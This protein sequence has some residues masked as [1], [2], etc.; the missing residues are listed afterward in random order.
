MKL[1]IITI[2]YNNCEGLKKTIDS[3][4]AQTWRDFEWIIIDGGSTDGSK[5]AIEKVATNPIANISFWCSEPDKGIYNAMN[6]G[7][8]KANGEYCFFLNSGDYLINNNSLKKAFAFNFTEDVVWGYLKMDYGD[9]F[10]FA[11]RREEITLQT[12]IEDTVNH[13]GNV[14]IKRHLFNENSYGLYDE[15]LRIV[16][17]WKW[18]LQVL[19]LGTATG[20]FIDI[21][22]SVVDGA[23]ISCTQ[24]SLLKQE[25]TMVL[26]K[27]VPERILK[28]YNETQNL[29]SSYQRTLKSS[30]RLSKLSF[31]I[32]LKAIV[33]KLL[34][35][36]HSK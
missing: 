17:D 26:N 13:T 24:P 20:R 33:Y 34:P 36:K 9:H 23:G 27:V 29:I 30:K 10:E 6:K 3:V 4:L 22:M 15:N 14:F 8:K 21:V 5:E 7:I 31:K 11:T 25:R 19:G 28:Y 16:S 12:F 18:F 35:F 2:N 32:L 1:S